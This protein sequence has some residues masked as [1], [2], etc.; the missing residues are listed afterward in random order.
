MQALFITSRRALNQNPRPGKRASM[1][2]AISASGAISS[3]RTTGTNDCWNGKLNGSVTST[4]NADG[5]AVFD[6]SIAASSANLQ[7]SATSSWFQT[8]TSLASTDYVWAAKNSSSNTWHSGLQTDGDLY[9]GGNLAGTNNIALN[10]SNGSAWF[11]GGI[12]IGGYASANTM[13]EYEEGAYT[14]TMYAGT[15]TTEPAYNWRYGQYVRVGE[16][17]HVWGALGLNGS[18]PS[19]TTAYI[20]NL[21]Y[22]QLFNSNNFFHYTQL[23]G[24]TW[25]SGYSDSGSDT[26]LFLQTANGYSN[27]VLIVSG[28][29]KSLVTHAMI[30]TNQRFTFH[31]SYVLG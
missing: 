12:G 4:I 9:L 20:G 11:T 14:P 21:P 23:H 5:S 18:M 22:N 26:K 1:S 2:A 6:G 17:V 30:G 13:D 15:G 7:S 19:C 10:G 28:A 16:V 25:A 3:N 24:Y 8:G 31:F 29:S 27:K